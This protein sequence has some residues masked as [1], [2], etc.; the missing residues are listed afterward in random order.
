M[1]VYSLL[2]WLGS[3]TRYQPVELLD[4][5]AGPYGPFF[6]EFIETQPAQLLY[7]FASEARAQ[8]VSKPALV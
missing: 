5:L 4:A 3:L 6:E 1:T 8:D 7:F 2:F